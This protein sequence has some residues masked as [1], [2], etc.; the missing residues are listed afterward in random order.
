MRIFFID[1]AR[2]LQC[3][4]D[5]VGTLIA[6][7]GVIVASSDARA[8]D[9]A[10]DNIY[11]DQ[12]GFPQGQPFKWSPKKSH[13]MRTN[14]IGERRKDFF[15]IVLRTAAAH[16]AQVQ[17][18]IVDGTR[19]RATAWARSHE[20]DVVAMALERF[21][22]VQR[23]S[24]QPGIVVA[25]Q[26]SGGAAD[27]ARFLQECEELLRVGTRYVEFSHIATNV[28]TT[29]FRHSRLLQVADLVTSATTALLA[30]HTTF[31]LPIFPEIR[32]MMLS[33]F[34]RIGG[35]GLKLH[36]D[37]CYANLYHWLL[38]DDTFWRLNVGVSMPLSGRPYAHGPD[39]FR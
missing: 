2:Q 10:L 32:A 4:R 7:G 3:S 19:T 37:Y 38:A 26:P 31:A 14:L 6:V 39:R 17:V 24:G 22:S 21:N 12:F 15:T 8:L 23:Q 16:G 9:R 28:L 35:I 27:E 18:T 5:G 25:A 13:W 1:D 33:N 11:V 34:G 29:P 20:M 36:P 30:G